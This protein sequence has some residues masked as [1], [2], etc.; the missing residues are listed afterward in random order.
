M[1]SLVAQST[2]I[3]CH[4][5]AR[6]FSVHI[7]SLGWPD[8]Y[9]AVFVASSFLRFS[10]PQVDVF[11]L[12]MTFYEMLSQ[13]TPFD[14]IHPHV[15]RNQE[16]RNKHRPIPSAKETRSLILFQDLMALCWDHD[17]ENRP[18][19][20]QIVD[21]VDAPEFER[22]RAQISLNGVK[23]ISCACVCRILPENEEEVLFP[24]PTNERKLFHGVG[25][26]SCPID[27]DKRSSRLHDMTSLLD[28]LDDVFKK[29]GEADDGGSPQQNILITSAGLFDLMKFNISSLVAI[30]ES[31]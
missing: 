17:P 29:Y 7:S 21:W 28:Q 14:N 24:Q 26:A 9:S 18:T 16:V 12:G 2:N 19:T 6:T 31:L 25:G 15:K 23:S 13:K 22:L 20:K 30:F 27:P 11:A 8:V 10:L 4:V 1:Q 5:S 3:N